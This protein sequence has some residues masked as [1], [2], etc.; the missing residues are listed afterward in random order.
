[1]TDEKRRFSPPAV[2][3]SS[4]LVIFAVLCL[5]VF[6]MLSLSTVLA[7][8]RLRSSSADAVTEYYAADFEAENI[9]STLRSGEI[10]ENVELTEDLVAKY[11]CPIS[12]TQSLFVEV[13]FY[14]GIG[15][16]YKIL[17]WQAVYTADWRPD[18]K[19][20]VWTGKE[21]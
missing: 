21:S 15:D 5:T 2:G 3:G 12:N 10:P 14:G 1:M 13:K 19:I 20:N 18:N 7:D 16:N 4:L 17:R 11:S 6:A 9:L 8:E